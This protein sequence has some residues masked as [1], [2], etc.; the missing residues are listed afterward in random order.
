L[1]IFISNAIDDQDISEKKLKEKNEEIEN[2]NVQINAREYRRDNKIFP[3]QRNWKHRVHKT[4]TDETKYNTISV[5]H[6]Y[7][8]TSTNI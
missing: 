2:L 3:I 5:G 4:K 7:T 8:Q 1:K 6:H